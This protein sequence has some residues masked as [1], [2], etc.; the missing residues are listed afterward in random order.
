MC[1]LKKYAVVSKCYFLVGAIK[2]NKHIIRN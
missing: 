1:V 2:D